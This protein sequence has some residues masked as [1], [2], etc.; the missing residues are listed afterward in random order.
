MNVDAHVDANDIEIRNARADEIRHVAELWCEAFPSARTVE[1]RA[2]MLESGG[3]YGGLENV[4]VLLVEGRLVAAC[5]LHRLEQSITGRPLPMMG[6]AAVAV[7]RTERR[8]G[9]GA[10]LCTAAI[11]TARARGDVLSVL[12]PFRPSYYQ[13]LGWGLVGRLHDHRFRATWLPRYDEAGATRVA[14]LDRDAEAI[15]RCYER[16]AGRAHGPIVRDERGWG[17]R[18]AGEDLGVR[19]LDPDSRRRADD[20]P[21]R[22]V[23]VHGTNDVDGYALLRIRRD[24]GGGRVAVVRELVAETEAAYRGILGLVATRA[25][26]WPVARYRARP[27]ERFEDRLEDPRPVGHRTTGSLYFPTGRIIR[28]PMLRLLDVPAA[29]ARRR[30]FDGPGDP[31]GRG[32][33][34]VE[35]ADREVP[36]N[37]GPWSVRW[38]GHRGQVESAGSGRHDVELRVGAEVGARLTA[39]DLSVSDASRLG[40][41]AASG[42]LALADRAFAVRETFWLPDEF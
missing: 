18:F 30:W 15:I 25:G 1:D 5:K 32:T 22:V 9:I 27:E 40:L 34:L 42:D 28:G 38:D 31:G 23:L 36:E 10:A 16:V 26:K 13:R 4:L 21:R 14:S 7:A 41:C 19:P 11:R 3:R 20:D 17:Y 12:Y 29:L 35:V 6:L 24:D 39:G 37:R 33:I 2:R 8:R